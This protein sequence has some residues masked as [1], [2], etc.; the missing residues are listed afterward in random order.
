MKEKAE[1][2]W[3]NKKLVTGVLCTEH[4]ENE[5]GS[6]RSKSGFFWFHRNK[7]RRGRIPVK[8]ICFH[9]HVEIT[10]ISTQNVSNTYNPL[11]V[12]GNSCQSLHCFHPQFFSLIGGS[13]LSSILINSVE[14]CNW[15]LAIEF[16]SFSCKRL[17]SDWTE[18]W[19]AYTLSVF[20]CLFV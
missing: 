1:D 20:V 19:T 12:P 16:W 3:A 5:K 18:L 13:I 11:R 7:H 15:V 8:W 14:N 2:G 17:R 9:F 6:R 10:F 4:D